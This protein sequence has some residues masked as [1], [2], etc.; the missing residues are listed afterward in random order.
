LF[1]IGTA[2]NAGCAGSLGEA[3]NKKRT[4][5]GSHAIHE[6]FFYTHDAAHRFLTNNQQPTTNNQQPTTNNQQPTTNNQQPTTINQQPSTNNHQPSTINQR[7]P[8]I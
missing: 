4:A 2:C 8:V 1:V 5:R 3:A 7:Q 6:L